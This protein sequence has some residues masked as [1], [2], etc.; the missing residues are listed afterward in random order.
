MTVYMVGY[1]AI[2]FIGSCSGISRLEEE[3]LKSVEAL[4]AEEQTSLLRQKEKMQYL[5]SL[6]RNEDVKHRNKAYLI[7]AL[8]GLFCLFSVISSSWM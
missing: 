7:T 4:E 3:Y 1:K 8:L 6:E 2:F 5:E